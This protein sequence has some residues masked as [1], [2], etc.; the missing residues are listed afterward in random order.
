MSS[1]RKWDD[2]A[3]ATQAPVSTDAAAQAGEIQQLEIP[4]T[5][6]EPFFALQPL[7]LLE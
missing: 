6:A 7:L 4:L 1:K 3:N 5:S 2:E